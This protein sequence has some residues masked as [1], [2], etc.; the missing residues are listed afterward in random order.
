MA[1]FP[2]QNKDDDADD[3]LRWDSRMPWQKDPEDGEDPDGT[4][5]D[6]VTVETAET[7]RSPAD[8]DAE[9]GPDEH[10]D[11][12][13]EPDAEWFEESDDGETWMR[14]TAD[15]PLRPEPD[16]VPEIEADEPFVPAPPPADAE[17]TVKRASI[18]SRVVI[19]GFLGA[20]AVAFLVGLLSNGSDGDSGSDG[21][22]L[23]PEEESA[24]E[25]AMT[26]AA[27]AY[28]EA[29]AAGDAAAALA[30]TDI[31]LDD[32]GEYSDYSL[33]TDEQLAAS[34]ELAP[35]SE[36]VVYD[37]EVD[38]EYSWSGAASVSLLRGEEVVE[39]RLEMHETY[40]EDLPWAVSP[41]ADRLRLSD[42]E[43]GNLTPRI[44]GESVR[45]GRSYLLFPGSYAL[46][47]DEA[48]VVAASEGAFAV[49]DGDT[50]VVTAPMPDDVS[51]RAAL[52]N[53][54]ASA[55]RVAVEDALAA[56]AASAGVHV[57]CVPA[58]DAALAGDD[59]RAGSVERRLDDEAGYGVFVPRLDPEDR[60]RVRVHVTWRFWVTAD[61]ED[62]PECSGLEYTAY[63]WGEFDE[64]GDVTIVWS[65]DG[66]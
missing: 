17:R 53:S 2:W 9:V 54:A 10:T 28:M 26:E 37:A 61:C 38:P 55:Y 40:D 58:A 27:E 63:P 19:F 36:I 25:A 42:Y 33:L 66:D 18:G 11:D 14:R 30:L 13:L 8:V 64:N 1:D 7:P 60:A 5:D 39:L 23:T 59:V 4:A 52:T 56:C 51:L 34:R 47:V 35:L 20:L 45:T 24:A 31:D 57:P 3:A 62:G 49:R 15:E 46:T 65:D 12:E 48:H 41:G 21:N 29:V 32:E 50:T 16:P 44:G 6:D 22:G 43:F